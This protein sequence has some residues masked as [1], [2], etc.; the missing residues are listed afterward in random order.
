MIP[1]VFQRPEWEVADV[2][3]RYGKAFLHKHGGHLTGVQ[4]Q[5]LRDLGRC[6]TAELG[7]HVDECLDCGFLRIAYNS[8]RNRHCPKCQALTRARWLDKQAEHLL[9]VEYFH[10]VFTLPREVAD[11]ALANPAVLYDLLFQAASATLRDVAANPKRLGA[12]VGTLLV[13]HT[14]GQNMHHHP[15]LHAVVTGGGLSCNA[16]GVIDASP[17][18]IGCRKGFFL[19]VKVLS[20]V[21]RGKYLTGLQQAFNEGK[22]VC[23]KNRHALTDPD[24]SQRWLS[25]LYRKDWVVYAKRPFGG[26]KQVLKYLARY[27][28]RVAISNARLLD[29][30]GGQVSFRYKDYADG[31]QQK[32]M[33]L[34]ADEFLRRF[35]QHV[36]P[37]RF[38]K[39]RHYGLLANKQREEKLTLC[40]LLL[41][42]ADV[43]D[44]SETSTPPEALIDAAQAPHCPNCGS[45]RLVRRELL[46]TRMVCKTLLRFVD[47]T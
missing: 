39:I 38:V 40:R 42:T 33:T 16:K 28:H 31:N 47:S 4:K 14:W 3:Q 18:W 12:Q 22:L 13:L 23:P 43:P 6:R 37:K 45:A 19:P 27:T 32:V 17:R 1:A 29:V 11:L 7:G 44:S 35:V 24:A 10:V 30:A 26:P 20:R 25:P 2:I 21:F 34:S 46:P 9:P 5:A 36:L 41:H 15:H 8:C